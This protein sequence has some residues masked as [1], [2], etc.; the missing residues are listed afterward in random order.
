MTIN[1][2]NF[3]PALLNETR[4]RTG[5]I[6]A[7]YVH[8]DK[9]VAAIAGGDEKYSMAILIPKDD[10]ETLGIIEKAIDNAIK[11]GKDK[12]G[13]KTPNK[14]ALKLPLRDGIERDDEAYQECMFI[15]ANNK[16]APQVVDA[17][18]HK[19]DPSIIYSGCYCRVT[20]QFYT[21]NVNGNRGVGASLGNVQFVEDG[22]PLG[23]THYTA[24]SDFGAAEDD[25]FLA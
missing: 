1:K 10:A 17:D 3:K 22:E 25:D 24:E 15:N 6:R 12:F 4:V 5:V 2:N 16:Q 9:P 13:G 7:S 8:V 20:I 21:F 19:A 18:R 14:A 23:G 11:I